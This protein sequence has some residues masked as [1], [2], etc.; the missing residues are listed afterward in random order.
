LRILINHPTDPQ[1]APPLAYCSSC[2]TALYLGDSY[3]QVNGL[4][5]CEDC[6]DKLARMEFAAHRRI[7]GEELI[8]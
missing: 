4:R 6:L 8:P 1:Q 2:G 5:F 7:C 3:W